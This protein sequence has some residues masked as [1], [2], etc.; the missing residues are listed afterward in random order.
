MIKVNTIKR[1]VLSIMMMLC[2]LIVYYGYH[3][4]EK[5]KQEVINFK[6]RGSEG[7][8]ITVTFDNGTQ[9]T[10]MYHAV[11]RKYD[12]ELSDTRSVFYESINDPYIGQKGD[13]F[14]TTESPFPS[15]FGLHQIM[16]F[17]VGGHAALNT[18]ENTFLEAV[19][20]PNADERIIDIIKDRSE[21]LHDYSVGVNMSSTNYWMTPNFRH[22]QDRDFPYYG[23]YYR[24][25]FMVLRIKNVND[26]I[27][28]DVMNYAYRHLENR[29]LYN[30]L[31]F[32]DT[33]NKFYC[34]D[35][36]SR[37][38]RYAFHPSQP[39][40]RYPKL[41]NDNG[42]V[43]TVND[44]ILSKDTY[45]SVYIENIENIRHIYYLEDIY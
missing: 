33:K 31:F 16:S 25:T 18:G 15:I 23:S 36:M 34:T 29:S 13:I 27:L 24:D 35:F 37:S 1:N 5:V 20:F 14:V 12:Y 22:E 45:L 3:Q 44:L 21:G 42:F 17:F 6:K 19:G 30:F 4:N 41:L 39:D 10:R 28:D 7:V 2:L 26:E 9:E 11:S 32:I 43:T 38:Y 40:Y 8:T